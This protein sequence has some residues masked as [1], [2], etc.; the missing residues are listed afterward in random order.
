MSANNSSSSGFTIVELMVITAVTAI[1]A[2]SFLSA[3]TN[4]YLVIARNNAS[5][6]LTVGSQNLLRTTVEAL[7]VGG[8]VRQT[9]TITDP[10]APA[11]GWTTSNSNFVIVIASPALDSSR[12]YIIDPSTGNPYMNELVYYKNGSSLMQRSLSNP[13]ATGDTLKTSCPAALA[14]A[15]CPADKD[16]AD[17]V[18][19]MVFTLYDQD[20]AL[21]TD[22]AQAKSIDISLTMQRDSLGAPIKL[23][24]DIRVTL[25]NN[26]Q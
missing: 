14:S 21:T 6:D 16:L 10:N 1:L 15:S 20:A 3:L 2:V 23:T 13:N 22:P 26:F 9:N 7:R 8:G 11:G 17:Y 19:S 18:N 12:N 25:R 24:N 5:I 4:Y